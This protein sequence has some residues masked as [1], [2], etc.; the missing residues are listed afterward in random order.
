M[1]NSI[2]LASWPEKKDKQ[3]KGNKMMRDEQEWRWQ[4][5]ALGAS[6]EKAQAC[7]ADGL[8]VGGNSLDNEYDN[9]LG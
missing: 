6:P 4:Q 2:R 8:D 1:S 3:E 7:W 9:K 5:T